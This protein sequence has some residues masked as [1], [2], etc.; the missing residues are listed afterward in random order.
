MELESI[1]IY[2][3][4]YKIPMLIISSSTQSSTHWNLSHIPLLKYSQSELPQ[5]NESHFIIKSPLTKI[6]YFVSVQIKKIQI[7]T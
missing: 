4:I 7:P 6:D 2:T 5:R 3:F 1:S